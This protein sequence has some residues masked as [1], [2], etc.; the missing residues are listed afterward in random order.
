M[1]LISKFAVSIPAGLNGIHTPFVYLWR[2]MRIYALKPEVLVCSMILAI[3][4]FYIQAVDIWSR[5]LLGKIQHTLG[6]TTSK[7]STLKFLV[8]DSVNTGIKLNWELKQDHIA[9]Y[10]VQGHR[11]RMEDRFVVNDDMNNTG[12]SLFA[13]F[14]GHGGEFAANYARDKLI[15]NINKKVIEL[16]NFLAGKTSV[17]QNELTLKEPEK[18]KDENKRDEKFL[19]RKKSFRKVVSTSLTDD[20]MKK[21]IEVTD[22][23]LLDKLESITPITREV[24]PCRPGEKQVPK[25]DMMNYIE[26]NKINYGRLLTDEVLA[27]DRLLV[28]T[29]KKN[30]DVAGTTALIALLEDNKLIVANVGDSRGVMCDEKGNA[31]P[32]SFDHKPQ[33]ERERK[34]INKAGGLVTFNGVWRVAG[35]L[36]TSRAL[37]DYPLKDKKLV[38]ADPDILTFDLNDHN[39]MFIILASDGLWD[40]FTNEEAVTFIKERINEPHFGAK[41]ITLQ[42]FYRG[43]AD[44][45]TVIVI[46]L[47]D[48]KVSISE[49]KKNQL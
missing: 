41:S 21:A 26:G 24:R 47:K 44:N 11:A 28:E 48:R 32:L 17:Y 40:T 10:A 14:D 25:V 22:P 16:K 35:I 19:E 36:A 7:V 43:S 6:R 20:C 8:N 1:K 37:G 38:I 29:A 12:V 4:L 49:D 31:I 34:R 13:I 39:P 27:A 3:I 45:I 46:N 9:A 15:S 5:A 33:Q 30:M 2:I 23:E 18:K 42:S